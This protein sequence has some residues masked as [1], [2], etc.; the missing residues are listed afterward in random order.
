M[1]AKLKRIKKTQCGSDCGGDGG[2]KEN[3]LI[4]Y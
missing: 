4:F 3:K 2:G 1:E